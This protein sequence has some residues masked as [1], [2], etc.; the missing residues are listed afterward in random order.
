MHNIKNLIKNLNPLIKSN[1]TSIVRLIIP[2]IF[3]A[4]VLGEQ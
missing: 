4:A 2:I 3:N 1:R